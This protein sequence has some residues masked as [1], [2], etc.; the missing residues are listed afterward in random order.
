[1]HSLSPPER[2]EALITASTQGDQRLERGIRA[3]STSDSAVAV[4]VAEVDA[5]RLSIVQEVLEAVGLLPDVA[6]SRAKAL[7]AAAV[8]AI[9]LR[10]DALPLTTLDLE[11][12]ATL[13]MR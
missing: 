5:Y 11:S 2:L 6:A 10:P 4:R 1:M 12:L 7:Y 8:G 3:W 9:V 13:M